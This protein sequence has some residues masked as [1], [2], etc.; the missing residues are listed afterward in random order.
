ML[1][2]LTAVAAILVML[3]SVAACQK[4]ETTNG[5][6]GNGTTSTQQD[7]GTNTTG[8]TTTDT[9]TDQ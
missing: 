5:T 3:F 1:R 4:K 8:T 9:T 7:S 6:N 2:K